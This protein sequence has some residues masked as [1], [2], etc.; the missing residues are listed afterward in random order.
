M[1]YNKQLATEY[2]KKGYRV[3]L[4]N[5]SDKALLIINPNISK[6]KKERKDRITRARLET[7][8]YSLPFKQPHCLLNEKIKIIEELYF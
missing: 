3:F 2:L 1:N 4:T 5:S 7:N 8:S 6:I